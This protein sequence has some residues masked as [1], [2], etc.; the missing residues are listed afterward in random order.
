MR[1]FEGFTPFA[2]SADG[3][4][5]EVKWPTLFDEESWEAPPI[6]RPGAPRASG[7]GVLKKR[8]R[9]KKADSETVSP[10]TKRRRLLA[11]AVQARLAAGFDGGAMHLVDS[12][13][14]L[15]I[16]VDGNDHVTTI[17]VKPVDPVEVALRAVVQGSAT[18][19]RASCG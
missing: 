7:N 1:P 14:R 18:R 16:N 5:R 3:E 4:K 9:P 19:G 12:S 2:G 15:S 13:R 8:G 6:S 10:S 11:A 17:S